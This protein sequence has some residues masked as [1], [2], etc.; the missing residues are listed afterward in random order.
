MGPRSHELEE[1]LAHGPWIQRLARH[2]VHDPSQAEDLVQ[3]AWLALLE[4]PPQ[5]NHSLRSWFAAVLRN[6]ARADRRSEQRRLAREQFAHARGPESP[7]DELGATLELSKLLADA[8][9]KLEEPYRST[10]FRRYYEGLEPRRIAELDGLPLKTVKSRLARGLEKLRERLDRDQ[11]GGRGTWISACIPLLQGSSAPLALGGIVMNVKIVCSAAALVLVGAWALLHSGHP[12]LPVKGAALERGALSEPAALESPSAQVTQ[13]APGSVRQNLEPTAAAAAPEPVAPAPVRLLPGRVVDPA[14]L[15]LAGV[16]LV[17]VSREEALASRQGSAA[18]TE[19]EFCATSGADGRFEMPLP[20]Q[21]GLLLGERPGFVTLMGSDVWSGQF[22][23]EL[24]VVMAPRVDIAGTVVDEHGLPVVA[25]E[26]RIGGGDRVR[27]DLGLASDS[28]V[29]I[30]WRARSDEQGRFAIDGAPGLSSMKLAAF[31]PRYTQSSIAMPELSRSDLRL[32]LDSRESRVLAGEVLEKNGQPVA[33]ALVAMGQVATRTDAAGRFELELEDKHVSNGNGVFRSTLSAF[34]MAVKPER[35]PARMQ[36]PAA[37]WPGFVTLVIGDEPLSIRGR[38]LD[39]AGQPIAGAVV[40]VTNEH[41]FGIVSSKLEA[42][43]WDRSLESVARH[44]DSM[45]APTRTDAKGEFE[46]GGLL[47]EDYVLQAF[48]RE[49]LQ[50]V[51]SEP[52]H[53]GGHGIELRFGPLAGV[54]RV[55]GRVLSLHGEPLAGVSIVPGR[56]GIDLLAGPEGRTLFGTSRTTDADGRFDFGEIAVEGLV[57][58]Y[59]GDQIQPV[60]GWK[61]PAGTQLS[62]IQ[63]SVACRCHVQVDLGDR[64]ELADS[65][66]VLDEHGEPLVMWTW[67]GNISSTAIAEPIRDGKSDVFTVPENA[68]TVVLKKDGVEV[69]RR[70][71]SLKPGPL[72][73]LRF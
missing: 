34:L 19:R 14:G 25:A 65:L 2:L 39:H 44:G 28:A 9:G 23:Q 72:E 7:H 64:P 20:Q 52:V 53:A 32:V 66:V 68:A 36:E 69:Q 3:R 37:G 11:P 45:E 8:V 43:G 16:R 13:S 12:E 48:S 24:L 1:L 59:I 71:V 51:E 10:L 60:I 18:I 21:G 26:L 27:K 50:M 61:A 41:S 63:I 46:I 6:L 67:M 62:Q 56:P 30:L 33:E 22:R 49:T 54:E 70:P 47:D 40:R 4:R 73:T 57:F 38:V 55:A 5:H 31:H 42:T 15:G 35:M 29:E 58:Q 17:C